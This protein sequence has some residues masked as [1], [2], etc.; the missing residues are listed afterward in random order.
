MTPIPSS[1]S[2]THAWRTKTIPGASRRSVPRLIWSV[3][4]QIGGYA[5]PT[6][7]PKRIIAWASSPACRSGSSEASSTASAGTPGRTAE[8]PA[9]SD[10]RASR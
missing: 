6:P 10:S 9:R 3:S 1:V 4:S 7:Y 8:M 5:T 2:S